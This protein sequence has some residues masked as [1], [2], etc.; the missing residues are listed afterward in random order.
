MI[1]RYTQ[2]LLTGAPTALT[3]PAGGHD[4]QVHPDLTYRYPTCPYSASRRDMITRY[5]QTLQVPHLP[6]LCLQEGH[7][8][9][10][11]PDLTGAPPALTQPA[12]GT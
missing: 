8:H 3:Q 9:L 1:T 2:P 10:V 4:H 7:D 5:T 6:L 12:G 11:H